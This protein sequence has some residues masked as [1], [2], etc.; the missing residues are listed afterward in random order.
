MNP[1][2]AK[3]TLWQHWERLDEL[4]RRRY[5][6]KEEEA[7]E[8][9]LYVLN[10]LEEKNWRRLC[11]WQ[12]EGSFIAFLAVVVRRLF[13]DFDRHKH[14]QQHTP[15]W[16]QQKND[17]IW[18]AAYRLLVVQS[19][20]RQEAI[21]TLV[22]DRSRERWFIEEVA[23]TILARCNQ[24]VKTAVRIEGEVELDSYPNDQDPGPLN[25]LVQNDDERIAHMLLDY[26]DKDDEGS[27]PPDIQDK[28]ARLKSFLH[29][30]DEDRLI[31]RLHIVDGVNL[32]VVKRMLQLNGDIYRRYNKIIKAVREACQRAGL[33]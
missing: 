18:H 5:P 17:S 24:R 10:K 25:Q 26:I 27:L 7:G 3:K 12:G 16:L 32:Q 1:D 30:D 8:A 23:H 9:L 2:E 6:G 11:T 28:L 33:S 19:F 15:K 20:S 13:T 14:G 29:L 22:S 21:E 31:A 4:A